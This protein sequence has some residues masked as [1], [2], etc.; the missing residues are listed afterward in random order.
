MALSMDRLYGMR[1]NLRERSPG[2]WQLRVHGGAGRYVSRTVRGTKREAER[3]LAKL[4]VEVD[5][6][7]SVVTRGRTVATL[8]N[9][10]YESRS[11]SWSPKVAADTRRWIDRVLLPAELGRMPLGRVRTEHVDAFYAERRR[12]G[13]SEAR[14]RR[15]HSMVRSMFGQGVRW[16]WLGINPATNTYRPPL[17]EK[18]VS[19]PK[20][21]V[22]ARLLA[23]VSQRDPSMSVFLTLAADTGARLGQL[24]ALRWSDLDGTTVSFTRTLSSTGDIRPLSKTKGRARTVDLGASTVRTLAAHQIQAK[25]LALG[26]GARLS[27]SAFMFS[28]DPAGRTPWKVDTFKH[29]YLKMRREPAAGPEAAAVNFHQLRHYVA[30]QLIAAGEDPRTVADRLGHSRA[31]TTV[32]MY[33]A[34]V[35]EKGRAAADLLE[36]ILTDAKHRLS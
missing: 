20:P 1:G 10:W 24:C 12:A 27:K 2:V 22:V 36:Q 14:V 31:S 28:D 21:E 33:A 16:E 23:H 4:V 34:S 29:R 13:L 19:P 30:T 11:A 25:E 8:A 6:G 15:I 7:R 32:D 9:K 3:A 5:E 17:P 18:Q 26:F 35:P